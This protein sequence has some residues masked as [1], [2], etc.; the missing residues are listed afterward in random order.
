M[1]LI[2]KASRILS[3]EEIEKEI[4]KEIE[5]IEE[6]LDFEERGQE[7]R[8]NVNQ[9]TGLPSSEKYEQFSGIEDK[10][11]RKNHEMEDWLNQEVETSKQLFSFISSEMAEGYKQAQNSILEPEN[12]T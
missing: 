4:E 6:P 12:L 1:S 5:E 3:N 10:S 8:E 7:A 9:W 11:S 2:L